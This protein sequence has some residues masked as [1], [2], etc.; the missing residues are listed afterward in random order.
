MKKKVIMMLTIIFFCLL[1]ACS[2]TKFDTTTDTEIMGT[3]I[4]VIEKIYGQTA[5][6]YI[7]EGEII[8]SGSQ[9]TIDLSVAK[10]ITFQAGDTVKVGYGENIREIHPLSFDTIYVDL[11]D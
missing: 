11:I 4:G 6:V 5:I 7:T 1:F 10:D 3:F 2:S 9:A 8:K